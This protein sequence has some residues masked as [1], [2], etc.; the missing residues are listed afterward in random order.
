MKTYSRAPHEVNNR[1]IDLVNRYHPELKKLAVTFDLLF[2][3]GDEPALTLHGCPC[4]AIVKAVPLKDRVKG[5]ADAE[6]LIDA[7]K[8][9]RMPDQTKDALLDHE[10]Y[11]LEIKKDGEQV[12]QYDDLHRPKL[13][14]RKHD[15][16]F[17]W[18]DEMVRRH[19]Q[20]S[21][22]SQQ[23]NLIVKETGQLYFGFHADTPRRLSLPAPKTGLE[24]SRRRGK[25]EAA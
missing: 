6:I 12:V 21:I 20:Y 25:K 16:E 1:V 4:Y 24:D 5:G 22:E 8:Y 9:S 19:G 23:A 7:D 13:K 14:L 3:H 15:R 18:F 11:H 17:G 2:V 10:L